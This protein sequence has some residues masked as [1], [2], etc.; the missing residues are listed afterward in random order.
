MGFVYREK[1]SKCGPSKKMY[2]IVLLFLTNLIFILLL[3]NSYP[4]RDI[5]IKKL[6]SR[7]ISDILLPYNICLHKLSHLLL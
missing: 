2:I 1:F 6:T 7:S 4:I 5:C 3:K